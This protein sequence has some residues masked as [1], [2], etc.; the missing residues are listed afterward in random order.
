MLVCQLVDPRDGPVRGSSQ[1]SAPLAQHTP[2]T[3]DV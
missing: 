2:Q 3:Q 1:L